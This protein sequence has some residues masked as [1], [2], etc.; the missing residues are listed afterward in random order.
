MFQWTWSDCWLWIQTMT[1]FCDLA[2]PLSLLVGF[3][4]SLFKHLTPCSIPTHCKPN[5][6]TS[7]AECGAHSLPKVTD[8]HHHITHRDG[9]CF[10]KRK[11]K[12]NSFFLREKDERW[13]IKLIQEAAEANVNTRRITSWTR[14]SN[15]M[16]VTEQGSGWG[17]GGNRTLEGCWRAERGGRGA[18]E[19]VV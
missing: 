4:W 10:M 8:E 13:E 7:S 15:H 19:R 12:T 1:L 16:I 6:T 5:S 2:L 18:E 14:R 9:L 17:G 11:I 3:I